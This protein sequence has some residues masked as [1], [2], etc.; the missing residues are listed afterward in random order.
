MGVRCRGFSPPVACTRR[1]CSVP[2]GWG[3]GDTRP[4]RATQ[5]LRPGVGPGCQRARGRGSEGRQALLREGEAL[6]PEPAGD[7]CPPWPAQRGLTFCLTFMFRVKETA[8]LPISEDFFPTAQKGGG[9]EPRP[10]LHTPPP[11]PPPYRASA[12]KG[13]GYG[14]RLSLPPRP[15]A[16]GRLSRETAPLFYTFGPK[17]TDRKS[18]V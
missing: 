16:E 1:L 10:E 15:S 7:D 17:S 14:V 4:V 18:V 2:S 3:A 9:G 5:N 8:K 11:P 12:P 13:G 6:G